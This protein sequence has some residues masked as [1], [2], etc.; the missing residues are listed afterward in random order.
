MY[1]GNGKK[2]ILSFL[3]FINQITKDAMLFMASLAPFL[4]GLFIR[5]GIPYAEKLLTEYF[6]YEEILAPYYLLFDLMLAVLTPLM[7][8]F[9]S[10]MVILGEIDDK[11]SGYLA[12]TPLGKNGYLISRLGIPMVLSIVVTSIVLMIFSL[13]ELSIFMIISVSI[14]V[15]LIGLLVSLMVVTLSNNKVEG[16]AVTKLSGI[17]MIGIP[18]PFFIDQ[19][20]QYICSL[21]PT[22]WL[23]KYAM[24]GNLLN[25]LLSLLTSIFWILIL[26][27]KFN[28]KLK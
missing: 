13:T 20:I 18:V 19:N 5:F 8:C 27:R 7:F 1:Y 10:A 26:W 25:C 2:L 24:N 15:S 22:Y 23:A 11:I 21:L 9:V 16:L 6:H 14:T 17:M 3:L 28:T 12:V 4:C